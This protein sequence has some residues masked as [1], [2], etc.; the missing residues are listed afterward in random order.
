MFAQWRSI[1]DSCPNVSDDEM[2]NTNVAE[3]NIQTPRVFV[4][5]DPLSST[6][7]E[8]MVHIFTNEI[9]SSPNRVPY[10]ARSGGPGDLMLR[11]R[12]PLNTI[13]L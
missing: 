8:S 2:P 4:L 5:V 12:D 10:Q 7:D 1:G 13:L 6:L 3:Q 11:T 9:E